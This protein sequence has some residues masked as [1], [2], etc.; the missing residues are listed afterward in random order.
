M[1]LLALGGRWAAGLRPGGTRTTWCAAA[2]LRG[3]GVAFWRAASRVESSRLL[4]RGLLPRAETRPPP[5]VAQIPVWWEQCVRCLHTK[6]DK[7]EDG[8]LIY[9]GNLARSVFGVKCFSY[10]TSMISLAL[11]P[12]LL[13]QNNMIFGSLPLQILFYGIMGSFTV[14]TPILLHFLTKGYV[15]RLY[16]EATTD[17]YK[18]ITY[19]AVLLETSTVFHQNDVKIPE[20]SHLFTTFYAKTKSLLVNPW[21]FPNPEDYNHLMGYDKPFTFDVEV[22]EQKL[23]ED[24]K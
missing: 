4:N 1:L 24:E 7:P 15:I 17:T 6:Y 18:A 16:H 5:G 20:S 8:R 11:L 9:T 10:S 19:N 21:L 2:A 3:S 23:H 22:S 13:S 12:H 14:I